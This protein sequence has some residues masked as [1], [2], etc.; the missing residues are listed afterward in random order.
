MKLSK[1]EVHTAP[2]SLPLNSLLIAHTFDCQVWTRQLGGVS[3]WEIP[4][5]IER[6]ETSLS[7]GTG[8][9]ESLRCEDP[10]GGLWCAL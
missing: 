6:S 5:Q 3:R 4:I 10:M 7:S 9:V 8:Q 2:V 1:W